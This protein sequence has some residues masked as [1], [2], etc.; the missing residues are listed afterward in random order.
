ME[1]QQ[2]ILLAKARTYP[3]E[4]VD[5]TPAGCDYDALVG[6][7]IH[8]PSGSLLVESDCAHPPATK[9]RDVE[10]GEDQKEY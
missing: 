8:R 2:H 7:W 4:S 1:I 9:K 5:L 3:L 10:T 6:A